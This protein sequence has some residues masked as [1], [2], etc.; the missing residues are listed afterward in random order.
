MT[1]LMTWV[2]S[3]SED[4]ICTFTDLDV[5][6]NSDD[7]AKCTLSHFIPILFTVH[8]AADSATHW[9]AFVF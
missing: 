7:L 6:C 3:R 4:Q 9:A 2:K 5:T 8:T 1:A